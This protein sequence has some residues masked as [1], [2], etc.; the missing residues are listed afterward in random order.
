MTRP[1]RPA[2][3][4]P[5]LL[6]EAAE[7]ALAYLDDCLDAETLSREGRLAV[8]F[9][10]LTG[11][12][13]RTAA[14]P[15]RVVRELERRLRSEL[16][17]GA[18][19]AEELGALYQRLLHDPSG[20][21]SG[22]RKR[23]GIYYTGGALVGLLV[24]EALAPAL[25]DRLRGL[26]GR[27]E[28]ERA[29]LSLR[30]CDPA[31]GTG[32]ILLGAAR[33]LAGELARLREGPDP[34]E[35]VRRDALRQVVT[36][37]LYGLDLDPLAVS[38]CR[39]LLWREAA[40]G[41]APP[42]LSAHLRAGSALAGS[43]FDQADE[44][45]AS[46]APFHWPEA[47]PEIAERG[48]FDVA[49]GNPPFVNAI[50]GGI[51][52]EVREHARR[53]HPRVRGAADL[54][55]YFLDLGVRLLRPGGRLGMVLPRALLRAPAAGRIR[56]ALPPELQPTL[57]YAPGR[58]TFFPGAAV[59]VCVL[60]LGPGGVCRVSRD[61]DPEQAT[62]REGAIESPHW[63]SELD[64]LT[65]S[66]ADP[67]SPAGAACLEERFEVAAGM[68]AG[69]AYRVREAVRDQPDGDDLKLVTTGLIDPGVCRWGEAKCRYLKRDYR[70]PR[71]VDE[72]SLPETVRRRLL[73]ARRPKL[74][75]AGLSARIEAFLDEQGE[76]A[77]AVSTW[78][79]FHPRDDLAALD[80]LLRLLLSPAATERFRR[81]LGANA[82]GG[83]NIT[84]TGEFL[85]RFPLPDD[86][87]AD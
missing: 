63:W 79:V 35:A 66:A 60:A 77:G 30:V 40:D 8:L 45:P 31:C 52:P 28:R 56:A 3:P 13:P 51:A 44:A 9:E 53:R 81:E 62:W 55:C 76:Y 82:L 25:Q 83:G 73:R 11:Q 50:E 87:P 74:L 21:S 12:A 59:Y 61:P 22:H 58:A 34:S 75:V 84:M 6:L 10:L 41:P 57:L 85:R 7:A 4:S 17:A 68:T 42:Q 38:L 86:F 29:L 64:R 16:P 36:T 65:R 1:S 18:P 78:A 72:A 19:S 49:L 46:L 15:D 71:V 69:E 27:A 32:Q 43:L 80:A 33:Y 23:S 20:S 2:R 54:A 5:P 39:T 47:F 14:L 26:Q 67:T 48:G 37:C 70:F 24:R